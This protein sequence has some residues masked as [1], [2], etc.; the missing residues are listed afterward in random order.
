MA[1]VFCD[2]KSWQKRGGENICLYKDT[3]SSGLYCSLCGSFSCKLCLNKI[4]QSI[5]KTNKSPNDRWFYEVKSYL[6]HE[7]KVAFGFIGHCCEIK[8]VSKTS[9]PKESTFNIPRRFDGYFHIP[10]AG[11]LLDSPKQ[12]EIDMHAIGGSDTGLTPLKHG[13]VNENTAIQCHYENIKPNGKNF[14]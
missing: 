1:C 6:R 10:S 5:S 3:T 7:D 9:L 4:V 12:N 2:K 13:V 8:K 14:Y 11:L